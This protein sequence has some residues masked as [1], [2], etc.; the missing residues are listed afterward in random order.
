MLKNIENKN[1]VNKEK[2]CCSWSGKKHYDDFEVEKIYIFSSIEKLQ[3]QISEKIVCMKNIS[4]Y[5]KT[6]VKCN[7][8]FNG[9]KN[10]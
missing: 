4:S 6:M 2:V 1:E 9:H 5:H 3:T 10:R 7:K 8:N